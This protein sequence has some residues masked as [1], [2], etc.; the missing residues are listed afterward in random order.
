MASET[1]S[2]AYG[3]ADRNEATVTA[4]FLMVFILYCLHFVSVCAG[5]LIVCY[6]GFFRVHQNENQMIGEQ[7]TVF[8][9]TC[10]SSSLHSWAYRIDTIITF[11]IWPVILVSSSAVFDKQLSYVFAVLY[12]N[13]SVKIVVDCQVMGIFFLYFCSAGWQPE[14]HMTASQAI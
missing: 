7:N 9:A 4:A 2:R 12:T 10:F 1:N 14:V 3:K 8:V 13:V 6:S 11:W 5:L